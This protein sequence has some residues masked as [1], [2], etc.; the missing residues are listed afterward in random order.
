MDIFIKIKNE[1]NRT[2]ID[3]NNKICLH[4]LNIRIYILNTIKYISEYYNLSDG[5]YYLSV[6]TT[7]EILTSNTNLNYEL[8]ALV[9]LLLASNLNYLF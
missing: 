5:V 8:T 6:N 1:N 7:D 9:C 2:L 3:Y 4:Y